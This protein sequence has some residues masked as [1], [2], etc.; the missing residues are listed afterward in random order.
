MT[1]GRDDDALT[2]DGD[3][4][5]TLA[6]PAAPVLP[7]GWTA[8]GPG[9]EAVRVAAANAG[10]EHPES[11]VQ[12]A[13][14]AQAAEETPAPALGNAALV[15]LG[16]FGGVFVLYA[17]GWYLGATRLAAFQLDTGFGALIGMP[18]LADDLMYLVWVGLA[19]LAGPIWFVT[20]IFLTRGARFW[21]RFVG[22]LGGVVLLVPWPFLMIGGA[23]AL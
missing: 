14:E 21:K 17:I 5:P 2:W 3:D 8:V 6:A 18:M 16:V 11:D 4:D 1:A 9:A 13:H 10:S 12:G 20:T 22:L 19:T 15:S 7:A 23:V